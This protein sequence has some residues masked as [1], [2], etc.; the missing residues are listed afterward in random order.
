MSEL[1]MAR[2][3]QGFVQTQV[4][5]ENNSV[6]YKLAFSAGVKYSTPANAYFTFQDKPIGIQQ[7][8]V[9]INVREF[10]PANNNLIG[11]IKTFQLTP[12]DND[13]GTK[14][15]I[16]F[17]TALPDSSNLLIF[18]T[19][20]RLY[21]STSIDAEFTKMNSTIWPSKD[22]TSKYHCFYSGLYS[23]KDKA[24]IAENTSYSDGNNES[25]DFRPG[26]EFVY[27]KANDIGATGFSRRSIEDYT[28]YPINATTLNKRYP[29]QL[30]SV[31]PIAQYGL[32]PK[33]KVHFAFD[34]N[35]HASLGTTGQNLRANL[36]WFNGS[37]YISGTSVET[38][39]SDPDQWINYSRYTTV[40]DNADGF[41]IIVSRYPDV[42]NSQGSG[43][44]RAMLL[45]KV[46]RSVEGLMDPAAI[47][48]NG[49]RMNTM[50]SIDVDENTLLVLPDTE[51]DKAGIV[52]GADFR[53]FND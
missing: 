31:S 49:I 37:S 34:M 6:K 33:D 18:T 44:V 17:M 12:S 13:P 5:S 39:P 53:E 4:L 46:S 14:A 24:I 48:V 21:S 16:Q 29:N 3:G 41:T 2:F 8:G 20:D 38:S 47:G 1:R 32:K 28:T 45:A 7:D 27:D 40:P 22:L 26:L 11:T 23:I 43:E 52:Y 15:F 30:I 19:G 10:N 50:V 51:D 25:R 36:R 9:G 42:A 35:G